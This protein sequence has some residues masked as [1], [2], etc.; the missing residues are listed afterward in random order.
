[1]ETRAKTMEN[2]RKP[3]GMTRKNVNMPAKL[4]ATNTPKIEKQLQT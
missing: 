4:R 1:M 2:E 3:T